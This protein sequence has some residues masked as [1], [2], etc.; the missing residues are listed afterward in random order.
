M[1][2]EIVRLFIIVAMTGVGLGLSQRIPVPEEGPPTFRTLIILLGAASGYVLGGVIGRFL[3]KVFGTVERRI[4]ESHPGELFAGTVGAVLGAA[5]GLIASIPLFFLAPWWL[6][7]PAA[8]FLMWVCGTFAYRMFS[9]RSEALLSMAGLSAR[10]YVRAASYRTAGDPNSYLLDTSA[11]IDGRILDVVKSG[12]LKGSMLVAPFVLEELQGLADAA[13]PSRRRRGKR[14]L[15]V[16]ELLR[17]QPRIDVLVID[18]EV[19]QHQDVDAKLLALARDLRIS[20]VTTDSNLQRIAELQGITVLNPNRLAISLRP[21][22]LPGDVLS[23]SIQKEG[24]Q[25][26]QGVGYLDDGTMVVVEHAAPHI[27]EEIDVQITS[28]T[29]TSRGRLLFA[30]PAYARSGSKNDQNRSGTATS[31]SEESKAGRDASTQIGWPAVSPAD[32]ESEETAASGREPR[33]GS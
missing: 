2:V 29:Q 26:G 7:Y 15:Q 13:D 30:V 3:D 1:F 8:A 4:E 22:H 24:E 14:G 20:L 23:V 11:I 27:G 18:D 25:P 21:S 32:V 19:P 31:G 16:L 12:F 28:T 5:V 10:P 17:E 6:G 9:R 33:S